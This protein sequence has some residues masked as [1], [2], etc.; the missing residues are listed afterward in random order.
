M[1]AR[2]PSGGPAAGRVTVY[3]QDSGDRE[4][5]LAGAVVLIE[6]A[7]GSW[8]GTTGADGCLQFDDG[9]LTGAYDMTVFSENRNYVSVFGLGAAVQMIGP[10][11]I[12]GTQPPAPSATASGVITNLDILTATTAT[13]A[14]AVFVNPISLDLFGGQPQQ[15]NR[16][17]TMVGANIAIVGTPNFAFPDYSL[18]FNPNATIGIFGVGAIVEFPALGNPVVTRRSRSAAVSAPKRPRCCCKC[19][20]APPTCRWTTN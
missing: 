15:P 7:S 4:T 10:T 20:S 13:I 8:Q 17:N 1:G 19:S 9:A 3:V 6:N 11:A 5:P 12:G 2:R 14:Q 18:L 16:A